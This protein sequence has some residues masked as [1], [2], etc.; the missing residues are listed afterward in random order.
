MWKHK[1]EH[2]SFKVFYLPPKTPKV[3][4]DASAWRMDPP[5]HALL[6]SAAAGRCSPVTM[7]G[8]RSCGTS[9]SRPNRRRTRRSSDTPTA[10]SSRGWVCDWSLSVRSGSAARQSR[11]VS[12]RFPVTHHW[13]LEWCA[14]RAAVWLMH[15]SH[16]V[17]FGHVEPDQKLL[18][19]GSSPCGTREEGETSC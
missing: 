11:N 15:F 7:T 10:S 19:T 16:L 5:P 4:F 13:T 14:S 8:Y 1:R 12:E 3:N 18:S 17:N 9:S 2:L 6:P